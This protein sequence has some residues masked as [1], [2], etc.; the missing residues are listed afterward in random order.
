MKP[1]SGCKEC[2]KPFSHL[3]HVYPVGGNL[4]PAQDGNY[5]AGPH[6]TR[7]ERDDP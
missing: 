2:G 5:R 3:H 6:T 1:G 4:G 7:Q